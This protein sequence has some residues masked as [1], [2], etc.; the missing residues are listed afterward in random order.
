MIWKGCGRKRQL[1]NLTYFPFYA[2]FQN[3][4]NRLLVSSFPP[5][6]LSVC[7]HL[8]SSWNL[9]ITFTEWQ[10]RTPNLSRLREIRINPYPANV[11]NMARS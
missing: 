9:N 6:R 10:M 5:F 4:E 8:D 7:P 11:E 1:S 2:H 3:Y